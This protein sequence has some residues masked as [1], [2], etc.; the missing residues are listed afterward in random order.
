[1][2]TTRQAAEWMFKQL[3]R[4]GILPRVFAAE[5]IRRRFGEEL[6]GEDEG[7]R[8]TPREDVLREFGRLSGGVAVWDGRRRFWRLEEEALLSADPGATLPLAG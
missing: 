2:A 6:V 3:K 5:V 1:M 4:E 8:P 7:G